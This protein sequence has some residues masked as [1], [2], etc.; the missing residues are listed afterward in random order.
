MTTGDAVGTLGLLAGGVGADRR[1]LD[2]HAGV[3]GGRAVADLAGE[4]VQATRRRA[5]LLLARLVVLRAVTAALEPLRREAGR[6]AAAEVHALL[7]ER[8]HA[9]LHGVELRL[10]V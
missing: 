4:A 9:G 1:A 6:H 3:D 10:P 5:T 8:H 7:V 2:D